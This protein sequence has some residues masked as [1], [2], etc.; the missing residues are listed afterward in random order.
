MDMGS[1]QSA[2]VL[3]SGPILAR[4]TGGREIMTSAEIDAINIAGV[5]AALRTGG[6]WSYLDFARAIER[7][8]LERAAQI[9]ELG[10]TLGHN[11]LTCAETIRALLDAQ[12]TDTEGA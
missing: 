8:A 9:C 1:H 12:S 7:Q 2:A 4:T 10:W 3:L 11:A 5:E 6:S